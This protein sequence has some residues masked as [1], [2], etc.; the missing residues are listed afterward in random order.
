MRPHVSARAL[1]RTFRRIAGVALLCAAVAIGTGALVI[2]QAGRSDAASGDAAI[3]MLS[4]QRGSAARTDRARQLFLD[5]KVAR[6]LLAG[7]DAGSSRDDLIA[8]GVREDAILALTDPSQTAQLREASDIFERDRLGSG[9]LIAEPVQTL[10]LLKIARDSGVALNSLP[11]GASSDIDLGAV[12]GEVGQYFRYALW[13][14]NG[15]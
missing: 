3:V 14:A 6:I 10:R 2:V 1:L 15:S 13:E 12:A 4:D 11:I 9:V 7:A 5:G 8:R